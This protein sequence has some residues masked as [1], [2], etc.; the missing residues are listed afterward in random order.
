MPM[1]STFFPLIKIPL[2]FDKITDTMILKGYFNF[3]LE[4]IKI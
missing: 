3:G 4:D 1:F 2:G